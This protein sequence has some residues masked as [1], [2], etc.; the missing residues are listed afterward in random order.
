MKLNNLPPYGSLILLIFIAIH[1]RFINA[2]EAT[3]TAPSTTTTEPGNDHFS[4][5]TS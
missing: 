3:T 4:L 1:A 2:D 5:E